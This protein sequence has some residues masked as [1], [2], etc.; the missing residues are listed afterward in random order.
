MPT[1]LHEPSL[2]EPSLHEPSLHEPS[3]GTVPSRMFSL[4]GPL[5]AIVL[6]CAVLGLFMPYKSLISLYHYTSL[7]KIGSLLIPPDWKASPPQSAW[8][9][10]HDPRW[11]QKFHCFHDDELRSHE[12]L[13]SGAGGSGEKLG[14]RADLEP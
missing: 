5:G 2:H 14:Q 7:N 3:S 9:E 10:R 13:N 1:I 11:F 8:I 12:P 6:F 4:K